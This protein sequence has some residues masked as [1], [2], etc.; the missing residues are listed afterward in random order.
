LKGKFP[1][2]HTN[3]RW[4]VDLQK[5]GDPGPADEGA[6]PSGPAEGP[7]AL[8]LGG[9][10]GRAPVRRCRKHVLTRRVALRALVPRDPGRLGLELVDDRNALR[11]E[12]ERRKR[13]S[14]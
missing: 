4:K 11:P 7:R 13:S 9:P 1:G 6:A 10:P 3:G 8:A 14:P 5:R 2:C 12:R